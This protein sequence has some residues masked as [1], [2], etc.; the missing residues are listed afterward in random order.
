MACELARHW[1][2]VLSAKGGLD[3][4]LR[5]SWLAS[6]E[7]PKVDPMSCWDVTEET[8]RDAVR[9]A[10]ESAAGPDG[11]GCLTLPIVFVT[12]L[13]VCSTLLFGLSWTLLLAPLPKTLTL[14]FFA[15]F[16][17]SLFGLN[18]VWAKSTLL[19]PLDL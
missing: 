1:G 18:R 7:V 19:L 8:L 14:P 15:V 5:A 6:A 3:K 9:F 2:S 17:K 13:L 4:S 10:S 16:R 12:L 11:M